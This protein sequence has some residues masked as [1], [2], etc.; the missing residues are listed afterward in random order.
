MVFYVSKLHPFGTMS[1]NF[2]RRTTGDIMF[3]AIK[4]AF[5]P[6]EL[7]KVAKQEMDVDM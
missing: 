5:K 1:Y 2:N 3:E 7:A 6:S 4:E